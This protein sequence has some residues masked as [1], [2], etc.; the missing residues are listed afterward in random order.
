MFQPNSVIAGRYQ[1]IRLVGQGGMSNLYLAYDRKYNQAVVVVKEMTAAYSDPKEQQLAVELFHR[2]AKLLASLN[3]R[4]IP[5]VYDYFQFAGKYYLSMEFID[6]EDLAQ[7]LERTKGPLPE[8]QVLEWGEQIATV[9]FYLHK[10]EPPIVFR[11]V[12]P[13]NIM[14]C[15]QGVKLIDFGIARHFDQAK[16]GDTMRIGSPGYAPPEQYAAQ[17]DPRS[18]IYALGVTL[19]HALTGRDP[20]ATQTPF[21]VPPARQLNP[22][23]SEATAAMLARATQLDPNDRYQSVLEMKNDIKHILS[24]GKQST[25]VVGAPPPPPQGTTPPPTV[26]A[27]AAVAALA[28][29]SA[30]GPASGATTPT[31]AAATNAAPASSSPTV[32]PSASTTSGSLA[33]G[34][35]A[36][37]TT[38]AITTTTSPAPKR[39]RRVMVALLLCLVGGTGALLATQPQAREE[40]Q[41][42]LGPWLPDLPLGQTAASPDAVVV[43]LAE[44]LRQGQGQTLLP[45]LRAPQ[46]EQLTPAQRRLHE[47][48]L[49]AATVSQELLVVNLLYPEALREAQREDEIYLGA[50]EAVT[51][52]NSQGG[53]RLDQDRQSRLLVVLPRPYREGRAA[54]VM[55]Q[56]QK[57][58]LQDSSSSNLETTLLLDS[59]SE[60]ALIP[61]PL[62]SA[63][64][65]VLGPQSVAEATLSLSDQ[66][67]AKDLFFAKEPSEAWLWA[68]PGEPPKGKK[69]KKV[70]FSGEDAVLQRLQEQAASDQS[71]LVLSAD[72]LANPQAL[73]PQGRLLLLAVGEHQLPKE[74]PEG[75]PAEALVLG[76]TLRP[77]F[78][79]P[80]RRPR[81]AASALCLS[82]ESDLSLT[83][84]RLFDALLLAAGARQNAFDG[85]TLARDEQGREQPPKTVPY[86]WTSSGW[87]PQTEKVRKP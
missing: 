7:K 35:V 53:L 13:S 80:D 59:G 68:L 52:L 78:E 85:V 36:A 49:L 17:T 33:S 39:G 29:T 48:N 11:D 9:L 3:H 21:L 56:L 84:A 28:A 20:T 70:E 16:K 77:L 61:A 75:I 54:E 50:S 14:L 83:A 38:A 12:K 23:L 32:A 57:Q 26:P 40:L 10:H 51:A 25:R 47:Q 19:H 66:L 41:T 71:T 72:Q 76:S 4:H 67:Q 45:L 44:A 46:M 62:A 27:V 73:R 34:A 65:V 1:V 18:D 24:R 69:I 55:A 2:E 64:L 30:S 81:L 42:R 37:N 6:G 5:K 31:T 8:Q 87:V 82:P 63:G 86:R 43:A 60:A 22:A 74:L 15:E 79:H 58:Q